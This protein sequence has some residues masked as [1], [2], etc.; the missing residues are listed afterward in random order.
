MSAI[1]HGS[2]GRMSSSEFNEIHL[3]DHKRLIYGSKNTESLI[4]NLGKGKAASNFEGCR[5]C[6]IC[7]GSVLV[8][9]I[10]AAQYIASLT[11]L[12]IATLPMP[13]HG[14]L[15]ARLALQVHPPAHTH[16][17]LSDVS[18]SQLSC[19]DRSQR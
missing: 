16:P 9:D 3:L 15:R 17:G 19:M 18:M 8:S 10:E 13:I 4:N 2:S 14:S 7:L 1:A 11:R 6:S 12:S 5:E